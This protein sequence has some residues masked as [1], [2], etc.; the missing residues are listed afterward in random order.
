MNFLCTYSS[1]FP[2]DT[3]LYIV[4]S[5]KHQIASYGIRLTK[6][7]RTSNIPE[8]RLLLQSGL[9]PNACNKFGES[10]IHAVCRRGDHK[11]LRVLIEAGSSIQICDDYGRTPLHDACWTSSPNFETI[12]LLLEQDPW[13]MCIADTRGASPLNYVRKAHWAVWIGYIEAV[14]EKYW[15]SL[16][17]NCDRVAKKDQPVVPPL[18]CEKP[19]SRPIIHSQGT[20]PSDVIEMISSGKLD[21]QDIKKKE[22]IDKDETNKEKIEDTE[23][24]R[25]A[26]ISLDPIFLK[27][28]TLGRGLAK[29]HTSSTS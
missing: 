11:L 4:I 29:V 3:T 27:S 17:D 19:N 23:P 14:S 20:L 24:R 7:I 1:M 2:C 28:S 8:V 21:P 16:N 6:A 18:C 13:L 5:K 9:S 12:T 15:P 10:I 25:R 22:S 26:G